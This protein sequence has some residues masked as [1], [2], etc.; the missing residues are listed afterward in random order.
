VRPSPPVSRSVFTLFTKVWVK[1]K[2]TLT[3]CWMTSRV[4]MGPARNAAIGS[5]RRLPPPKHLDIFKGAPLRLPK[6][7]SDQ[8]PLRVCSCPLCIYTVCEGRH[9][10]A[11]QVRPLPAGILFPFRHTLSLELT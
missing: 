11:R 9:G 7:L 8:F 4:W 2:L 3:P 6:P 5:R 10:K 1:T